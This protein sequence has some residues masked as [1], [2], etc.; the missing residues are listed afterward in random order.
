M[1]LRNWNTFDLGGFFSCGSVPALLA[2]TAAAKMLCLVPPQHAVFQQPGD[3]SW[4]VLGSSCT[5]LRHLS[6]P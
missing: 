1:S 3:T 6:G 5:Q 4:K 2:Q